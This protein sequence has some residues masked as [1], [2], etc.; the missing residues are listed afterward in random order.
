MVFTVFYCLANR[1]SGCLMPDSP[2]YK[3]VFYWCIIGIVW[4]EAAT[5]DA[6][7]LLHDVNGV[8]MTHFSRDS[9]NIQADDIESSNR[10]AVSTEFDK[11]DANSSQMSS[12]SDDLSHMKKP[13]R[14]SE[15]FH[16]TVLF[17]CWGWLYGQSVMSA[18]SASTV[19]VFSDG[20]CMW[21]RERERERVYLP[22]Q[23]KTNTYT[24]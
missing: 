12:T 18:C 1:Q 4:N 22:C 16:F 14:S 7:I 19:T 13:S 9:D 2:M 17:Q 8:T 3:T 23:N 11:Y 15:L 10:K 21:E 24:S 5:T 20:V 6:G